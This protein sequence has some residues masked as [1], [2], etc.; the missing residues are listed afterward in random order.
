M[1]ATVTEYLNR[2]R[3]CAALAEKMG[4]EDKAKLMEIAHAWLKLAAERAEQKGLMPINEK[5]LATE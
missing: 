2:A 1:P 4:P 5:K 3:V